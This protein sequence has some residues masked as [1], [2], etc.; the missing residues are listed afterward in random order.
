MEY[1]S[2]YGGKPGHS[3]II[4]KNYKTVYAPAVENEKWNKIIRKDLGLSEDQ[5]ISVENR[6]KWLEIY[7][8]T[9]SFKLGNLYTVVQYD[10]YVIINSITANDP[11]NGKVF[12]RGYDINND[13]GG[14]IYIGQIVGPAGMA[15]HAT[16]TTYRKA[17]EIYDNS[18][19][20]DLDIRKTKGELSIGEGLVPGKDENNY[21]D[22]VKYI[23][24]S[25]RDEES[26]ETEVTLGFTIPY[27]IVDYSAEL[28]EED[29]SG[30]FIIRTD[31][32]EHPFYESWKLS[33]PKSSSFLNIRIVT[34][35][36]DDNVE[37][38]AQQEYD[39][40]NSNQIIVYDKKIFD[41]ITKQNILKTYYLGEHNVVKD[42]EINWFNFLGELD[43]S[44]DTTG[45][46]WE[47]K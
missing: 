41:K 28:V 21:N 11:D 38:Y 8:M 19:E 31:N 22:T 20:S 25:V 4:V 13:L 40:A 10:E 3:P 43:P 16:L 18:E 24:V 7:C 29:Y 2:F 23:T 30:D 26:K 33:I 35:A 44:R 46:S 34:A 47:I 27:L 12:R 1:N 32:K 45:I 37:P 42:T 39:R 9:E 15:P 6:K 14:A 36:D 17:E 5:P